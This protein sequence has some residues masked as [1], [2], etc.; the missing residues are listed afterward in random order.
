L[1]G[2]SS[3][4]IRDEHTKLGVV[5]AYTTYLWMLAGPEKATPLG[6]KWWVQLR[7]TTWMADLAVTA[8]FVVMW[9]DRD[10]GHLTGYAGGVYFG[11][12]LAAVLDV[13]LALIAAV[14]I[15]VDAKL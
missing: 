11:C 12:V 10:L 9:L 2:I 15:A 8:S 6:S 13:S 5:M 14:I 1:V 4:L 3:E 7:V